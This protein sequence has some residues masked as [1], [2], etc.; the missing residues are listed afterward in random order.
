[1][2]T[3]SAGKKRKLVK[4]ELRVAVVFLRYCSWFNRFSIAR[5]WERSKEKKRKGVVKQA[6]PFFS[7]SA[8]PAEVIGLLS[9]DAGRKKSTGVIVLSDA[10]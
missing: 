1:M 6:S 3:V 4:E 5:R 2:R 8:A 10:E 9:P 7:S